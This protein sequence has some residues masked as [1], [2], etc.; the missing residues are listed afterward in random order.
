M[1]CAT[2]GGVFKLSDEKNVCDPL[3]RS[4]TK[5]SLRNDSEKVSCDG[6]R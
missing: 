4:L 1:P 6:Q 3:A 5:F 2:L